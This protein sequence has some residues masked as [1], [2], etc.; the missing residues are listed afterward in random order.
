MM[1]KKINNWLS[2]FNLKI[3]LNKYNNK[4][5]KLWN[6]YFINKEEKQGQEEQFKK[7]YKKLKKFEFYKKFIM[8]K[9]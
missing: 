9:F 2:M 7:I 6:K 5:K 4:K 3:R 8:N 1:I